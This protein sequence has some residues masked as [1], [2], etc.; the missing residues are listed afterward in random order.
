MT[1]I[2]KVLHCGTPSACR[3]QP[4]VARI[5]VTCTNARGALGLQDSFSYFLDRQKLWLETC[6][7]TCSTIAFGYLRDKKNVEIARFQP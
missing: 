6:D 2:L 3:T 4:I 1:I 5:E 7:L